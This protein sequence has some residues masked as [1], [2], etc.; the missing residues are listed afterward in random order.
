MK[1]KRLTFLSL[2]IGYSL[3]LYIVETYIPNPLIILFPGAKLG[4]TNIITLISLILLGGKDTFIIVTIRVILSSIF[5]G[6]LSY[7][8][9]SIGGD[10][11]S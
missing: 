8:L 11:L 2:M 9:F 4:L 6:P 10:Y 3:I 7:L 1:T 5:S